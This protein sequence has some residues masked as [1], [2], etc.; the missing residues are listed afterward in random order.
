M[1]DPLHVE[2]V[3]ADRLVWQGDATNV[4]VRTTEGDIGILSGHEPL[5]AVLVPCAAEI[6][7]D[8]GRRE[9]VALDGGYISVNSNQVRLLAQYASLSREISLERARVELAALQKIRDE[10][11]ATDD[12]VHRL[13]LATA[14]VKAAEKQHGHGI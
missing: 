4:I 2:V 11:D 9:I 6:V 13:H 5:L 14:Q 12:D 1:A 3:A 8:D 7:T 10:G